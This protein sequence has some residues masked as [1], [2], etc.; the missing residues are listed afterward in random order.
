[1]PNWSTRSTVRSPT[2]FGSDSVPPS[3]SAGWRRTGSPSPPRCSSASGR[4]STSVPAR[5]RQAPLMDAALGLGMG[6]SAGG[7]A[8]PALA[9]LYLQHPPIRGRAG[10]SPSDGD[11]GAL[12][13]RAHSAMARVLF[14]PAAEFWSV[15][16]D[17]KCSFDEFVLLL[18]SPEYVAIIQYFVPCGSTPRK[19]TRGVV[20]AD[21]QADRVGAAIARNGQRRRGRV[22][23]RTDWGWRGEE[24]REV[25]RWHHRKVWH[26]HGRRDLKRL[27]DGR[28]TR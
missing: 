1:M 3:K 26:G 7:G 5:L 13:R 21:G 17:G 28:R 14:L 19:R 24:E 22:G 15:D 16:Q 10:P 9:S 20:A 11:R 2:S 25:P 8:S 23:R 4:H 6:L 27:G 12:R 18:V